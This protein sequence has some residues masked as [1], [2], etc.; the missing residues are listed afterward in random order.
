MLLATAAALTED[1]L[2]P[3]LVPRALVL[4]EDEVRPDAHETLSYFIAQGVTL[5]VISG[6]HPGTVAAVARRAGVPDADVGLDARDLPEDEAA[7]AETVAA[8]T[9]FGRVGPRQ[10]RAMVKAL[11]SQGH[12]VAMTGDGVND[13]L[14]L[15]D[16]DM[17]IAMGSGSGASR[18]VAQLVLM[19]DKFSS[20]PNVL[21]EGRRVMNSVERASNLFIY[22]S[23]YAVLIS[24]VVSI[25]GVDF[26]F[27]P[28]HLTLVR[29]LSVGIPGVFLA[30]APDSRRARP[31]FLQRVVRFSI[32]A[33]LIA[34][35]AAL[36]SYFAARTDLGSSLTD[37][38][39]TAAQLTQAR[40]AA[41][42]T[43]LGAGLGILVRLTGTLPRW[44]WILVG[45]MVA[46]TA[47]ALVLPF[48]KKFFDLDY[49]PTAVWWVVLGAVV[50]S[51]IAI[52]F[53]LVT[54]DGDPDRDV[55]DA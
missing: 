9:V 54:V 31:G 43:L 39:L 22:G 17:G 33:G 7:L 24:L 41:T 16:A 30:L 8:N 49:P 47:S 40:T 44:R 10:K 51:W 20:L 14:A 18:S 45:A 13:V 50:C 32:P 48:T 34:G 2:P 11:Q 29:A 28:R 55:S 1:D 36:V 15:K 52:R 53:V 4:L 46:A 35:S 21:A 5:K 23:A 26:P 25:F 12:V 37:S 42:V 6:D 3:D 19:D 38:T 27:L